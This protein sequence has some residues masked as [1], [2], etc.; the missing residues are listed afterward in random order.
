MKLFFVVVLP[1]Y[2]R[3][4]LLK[5]S[6]EN[7][8]ALLKDINYNI[9]N[10][11]DFLEHFKTCSLSKQYAQTRLSHADECCSHNIFCKDSLLDYVLMFCPSSS[12]TATQLYA[13]SHLILQDKVAI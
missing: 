2:A 7:V 12:L 11:E 1:K 3:V 8:I 6:V 10:R 13:D 5:V 9:V 4:N